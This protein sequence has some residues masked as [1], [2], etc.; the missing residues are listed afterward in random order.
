MRGIRVDKNGWDG[1]GKRKGHQSTPPDCLGRPRG[2]IDMW[3]GGVEGQKDNHSRHSS[4]NTKE[5]H[6][7]SSLSAG[8][9]G[10]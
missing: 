7:F 9:S 10:E 5:C 4:K 6:I 2:K 3:G 1:S 8:H